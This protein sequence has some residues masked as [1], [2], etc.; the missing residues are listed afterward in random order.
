MVDL[1]YGRLS[2]ETLAAAVEKL[3][4]GKACAAVVQDTRASRDTNEIQDT[5]SGAEKRRKLAR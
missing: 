1:V 2:A 3:P 4:G 5:D